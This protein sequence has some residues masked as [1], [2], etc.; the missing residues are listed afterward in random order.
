MGKSFF[1]C[2]FFPRCNLKFRERDTIARAGPPLIERVRW[3]SRIARV[4]APH[5]VIPSIPFRLPLSLYHYTSASR[6]SARYVCR[7]GPSVRMYIRNAP[8][9]C[10]WPGDSYMC[11]LVYTITSVNAARSG[12]R[13]FCAPLLK[14]KVENICGYRRRWCS[15]GVREYVSVC[16]YQGRGVCFAR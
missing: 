8:A 1:F 16:D 15:R 10:V 5:A 9:V 4:I 2:F 7:R 11:F 12:I 6:V 13:C 3:K 14:W